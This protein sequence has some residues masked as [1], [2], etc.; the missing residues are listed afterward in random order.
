MSEPGKQETT[1]H[2]SHGSFPAPKLPY[3][4]R[5]PRA[6]RPGIG[7]VGCGGITFEHLSAYRGAGYNVVALCDL[8]PKRAKKRREEFYPK[9]KIY[10]DHEELIADAKVEVVDVTTHPPQ[11]PPILEAAIRARKHVLSQKPYTTDLDDGERLANLAD[12]H[13]VK[14][15]VNQNGRWAPHFSYLR[16]AVAEGLIGE[17]TSAHF[18]VHWDH[19]WVAGTPFDDVRHLILYDFA[20]HW[21][22]ML[23]C[24]VGKR[25]VHRVSASFRRSKTQAAKPALLGQAIVDLD[26]AQASLVFDG[27]TH[28]APLDQ[29]YVTGSLGTIHSVGNDLKSQ[30]LTLTTARGS[31]Q[32]ELVG[33][34]FPDGFH[35]TMAELLCAIEEDREPTN[36]ARNNLASLAL[37]FAAVESAER[38]R[39]VVPGTVRKLPEEAVD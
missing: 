29:A 5:D 20:I 25:H 33:K 21:F 23:M 12:E 10:R 26:G 32:P 35:G 11:R 1:Q 38:G 8:D 3:R 18:S 39:P 27:D 19:N 2:V 17:L 30:T 13:R 34:W 28:F 6:Y 37:C 4:P 36:S 24:L 16:H 7:L 31:T 14:L 22:D 15:A 9:A